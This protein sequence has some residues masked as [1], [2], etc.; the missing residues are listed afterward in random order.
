MEGVQSEGVTLVGEV[1]SRTMRE[2]Q[3]DPDFQNVKITGQHEAYVAT[4]SQVESQIAMAG[5]YDDMRGLQDLTVWLADRI[6]EIH[7][8]QSQNGIS[9]G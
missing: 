9:D 5:P 1:I 7:D 3:V 8:P 4:L 2:A 6:R